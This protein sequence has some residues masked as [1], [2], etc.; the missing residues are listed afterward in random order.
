MESLDYQNRRAARVEDRNRTARSLLAARNNEAW[1]GVA[2]ALGGRFVAGRWGGPGAVV[3]SAGRWTVT[4]DACGGSRAPQMNWYTFASAEYVT[5][6]GL[7]FRAGRAN[8]SSRLVSRLAF[9]GVKVG[10]AAFD[11]AFALGGSDPAKVRAVFGD[12]L[13]RRALAGGPVRRFEAGHS[14]G[15]RSPAR[16]GEPFRLC[17][18]AGVPPVDRGRI[19]AVRGLFSATLDR[20]VAIGSASGPVAT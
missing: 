11:A 9:R 19:D 2:E 5:R 8:A 7:G 16:A 1:E 3:L 15:P 6:D 17:Y 12:P 10:D 14:R 13:V 4:L 20:L 18:S